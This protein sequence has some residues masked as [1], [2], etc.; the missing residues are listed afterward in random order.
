MMKR[1]LSLIVTCS[2]LWLF[3]GAFAE[4]TAAPEATAEPAVVEDYVE[5]DGMSEIVSQ[6]DQELPSIEGLTPLYT[7]KIKLMTATGS[8]ASIRI[9]QDDTSKTLAVVGKD[10]IV[11]IYKVYPAFVLVEYEGAVGFVKRTCID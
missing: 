4:E 7:T 9:A 3:P 10:E 1:A 8:A 6:A 11:T 5:D 2:L